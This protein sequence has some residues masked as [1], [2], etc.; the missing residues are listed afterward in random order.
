MEKI[1]LIINLPPKFTHCTVFTLVVAKKSGNINSKLIGFL[2][3]QWQNSALNSA[4]GNKRNIN[5][6]KR[7]N[8]YYIKKI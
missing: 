3:F 5:K 8:K 4:N 2:S 6:E 7:M 1:G